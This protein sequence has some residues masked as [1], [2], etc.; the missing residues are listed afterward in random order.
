MN[1]KTPFWKPFVMALIALTM[2]VS[3]AALFEA[4]ASSGDAFYYVC[5]VL[6][7]IVYIFCLII[8]FK[9]VLHEYK[10]IKMDT[11]TTELCYTAFYRFHQ[12]RGLP[13][14]TFKTTVAG[15]NNA[16]QLEADKEL[17]KAELTIAGE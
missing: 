6:N 11:D 14:K 5:G 7:L 12:V 16:V 10:V 4:G 9:Y 13:N 1:K 3:T 15:E 8:Y 17:G 2:C